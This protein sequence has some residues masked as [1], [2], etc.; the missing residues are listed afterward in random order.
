MKR[1]IHY[2]A[3][4]GIAILPPLAAGADPLRPYV[5]GS[6]SDNGNPPPPPTSCYSQPPLLTGAAV[7]SEVIGAYGVVSEVADDFTPTCDG[8]L[9]RVTW[10]GMY[11]NC[12]PCSPNV[13]AF[14]LR[15]YTS[16]TCTSQQPWAEWLGM[17]VTETYVG[18]NGIY[19]VYKYDAYVPPMHLRGGQK[20]WFSTQADNHLYPP[21]WGRLQATTLP[22][23][24][25]TFRS[26]YFGY[27]DWTP[28]SVV[29]GGSPIDMSQEFEVTPAFMLGQEPVA[30]LEDGLHPSPVTGLAFSGRLTAKRLRLSKTGDL[31]G[32]RMDGL[33]T[34]AMGPS[35]WPYTTSW[36]HCVDETVGGVYPDD[37][38]TEPYKVRNSAGRKCEKNECGGNGP[39][40]DDCPCGESGDACRWTDIPFPDN[41]LYIG[42]H[43]ATEGHITGAF[44]D[45][46]AVRMTFKDFDRPWWKLAKPIKNLIDDL[47]TCSAG[48][49]P[50]CIAVLRDAYDLAIA[51][52]DMNHAYKH[53][54]KLVARHTQFVDE[55]PYAQCL[56]QRLSYSLDGDHRARIELDWKPVRQQMGTTV[57]AANVSWSVD[58]LKT[59]TA[60]QKSQIELR[61]L[62]EVGDVSLRDPAT[63]D[64]RQFDFL[65]NIDNRVETGC[66]DLYYC[67][68]EYKVSLGHDDG[69]PADIDGT[70]WKW[71]CCPPGWVPIP[72]RYPYHIY[73]GHGTVRCTARFD[74]LAPDP[75]FL[76]TWTV[77]IRDGQV[78][79]VLDA[80]PGMQIQITQDTE[81]PEVE[82]VRFISEKATTAVT[83]IKVLFSEPVI[84]TVGD[85]AISPPVP[86]Y[87]YRSLD[88]TSYFIHPTGGPF[89]PGRYDITIK[90][91]IEDYA[92]NLL[93]RD[94]DAACGTDRV[95]PFCVSDSLLW[96]SDAGGTYQD[97]FAVNDPVYITG[98]DFTPNHPVVF[99]VV[100]QMNAEVDG[101]P[102]IDLS[103]DGP[104]AVV[105]DLLGRVTG[106]YLGR[107]A[108]PGEY[109][110]VADLDGDGL[111]DAQDDRTDN[112][113]EA[114]F[115]FGEPCEQH[116][117]DVAAW[118]V[119][120]ESDNV[121]YVADLSGGHYGTKAN[122]PAKVQGKV[123]WGLQFNGSNYCTIP[124]TGDLD[125]GTDNL[126]FACW[127]YHTG[128]GVRTIFDK[129]G[130]NNGY[131]AAVDAANHLLVQLAD[132]NGAANWTSTAAIPSG[133]WHHVA[134][135]IDR[136]DPAGLKI[137]IDGQL[138]RTDDPRGRQGDLSNAAPLLIG[139]HRDGVNN[140]IGSLDEMIFT[141]GVL[142]PGEVQEV[143]Q[144]GMT[145]R[146]CEI[147]VVGMDSPDDSIQLTAEGLPPAP[148]PFES[149]TTINFAIAGTEVVR[150]EILDLTGRVVRT[151]VRWPLDAGRHESFWDA[152]DDEGR[153]VPA[154]IYFYRLSAGSSR[155]T[156]KMILID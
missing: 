26:Q 144:D 142:S 7:S 132:G 151:L 134:C 139:R 8:Q 107:C 34:Y 13:T 50:S 46:I 75:G 17:P 18:M 74:E 84:A 35:C 147:V 16:A 116:V 117:S 61:F 57:T 9:T 100:A 123:G 25:A 51:I 104:T 143:Y 58:D 82:S 145:G 23:C 94:P 88:E 95:E 153:R 102:L 28:V 103:D 42:A 118:Y 79:S 59:F 136:V 49:F 67:G 62:A 146:R 89:D 54:E 109:N 21:Q 31:W 108:I 119:F 124:D 133:S 150:L 156:Q 111:M 81:C 141:T 60:W 12:G 115:T 19:P 66:P 97:L 6:G 41:H 112:L 45:K 65:V 155:T 40:R 101:A 30:K 27:P 47:T 125:M 73:M 36:P 113:C 68:A 44:N 43:F 48:V 71:N 120:E 121:P 70:M 129:R 140:F 63:F 122:H 126:S 3:V 37:H 5:S 11:Y 98:R 148:N 24:E 99:H 91:S 154:G 52:E 105:A 90:G 2:L 29:V 10:W 87:V 53:F 128:S 78:R 135:T 39:N 76:S 64:T 138:D 131:H 86:F 33:Y 32:G 137:Y 22:Q 72:E 20:Y 4:L 77:L 92:G 83:E 80:C 96:V 110:V 130:P 149:G 38:V 93:R 15:I 127:I 1:V 106:A 152:T 114:G 69:D 55:Q 56:N 85:F 14:N